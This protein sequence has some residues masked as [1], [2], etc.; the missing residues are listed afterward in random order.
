[1]FYLCNRVSEMKQ[2]ILQMY[3]IIKKISVSYEFVQVKHTLC[4][5]NT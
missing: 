1:M 2:L 4:A 5:G 3:D